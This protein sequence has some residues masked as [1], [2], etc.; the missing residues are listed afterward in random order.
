MLTCKTYRHSRTQNV[1]V[2]TDMHTV[3]DTR[4]EFQPF[5]WDKKPKQIKRIRVK[6]EERNVT[7]WKSVAERVVCGSNR[8]I[9]RRSIKESGIGTIVSLP[10]F[11]S[12]ND[13]FVSTKL[14]YAFS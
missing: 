14:V 1:L 7:V 9:P 2:I 6:N 4:E 11:A 12:Y 13:L 10:L 5:S 8:H 3:A